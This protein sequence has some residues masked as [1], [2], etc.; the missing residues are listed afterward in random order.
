MFLSDIKVNLQVMVNRLANL[1]KPERFD[2]FDTDLRVCVCVCEYMRVHACVLRARP[3][4]HYRKDTVEGPQQFK[5]GAHCNARSA[6]FALWHVMTDSFSALSQSKHCPHTELKGPRMIHCL[7]TTLNP[8]TA[9]RHNRCSGTFN[10]N[11]YESPS[12]RNESDPSNR[13]EALFSCGVWRDINLHWISSKPVFLAAWWMSLIE[14]HICRSW[15]QCEHC[16][17]SYSVLF[18]WNHKE[19]LNY[20]WIYSNIE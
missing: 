2:S 17:K 20:S 10:F 15:A 12:A 3:V 16:V 4:S 18:F 19:I 6:S 13:E 5:Q 11:H 8:K 1:S 9:S 14:V 7:L